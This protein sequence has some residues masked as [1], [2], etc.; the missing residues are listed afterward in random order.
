MAKQPRHESQAVVIF[1]SIVASRIQ[2]LNEDIEIFFN[3]VVQ[4]FSHRFNV[5]D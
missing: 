5:L 4:R 2:P 3:N 1:A